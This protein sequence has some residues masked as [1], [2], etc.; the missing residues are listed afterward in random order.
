MDISLVIPAYNE[1]RAIVS[2]I[3]QAIAALEACGPGAHEIIVVDDGSSDNTAELAAQHGAKVVQHLQNLGYGKSLKDGITNAANDAIVIADA[4]G[5]Y[6]IEDLPSL[7]ER[8]ALGFDM[9][10][11]ERTGPNYRES[12]FKS[13]LRKVL[14]LLVEFTTGRRIPDVNSG[15]RVFDRQLAMSYFNHLCDT[16]SFTT[17]LTLSYMMNNK[18]VDYIPISYGP[19]IG[20]TK[21]RL[22]SDSMRT[23]QYISQAILYYDPLKIFAAVSFFCVVL[24]LIGFAMTLVFQLRSTYFLA[25][26]GMLVAILVFCLGLVADLLKQILI[27]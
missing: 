21:V 13:P 4:D 23:L 3:E 24:S 10:V 15:F 2:T 1:E 8:Y 27:K 19:R 11:G 6:P 26:G 16:L 18:F 17:S 14:K 20:K 25:I 12:V 22:L 5:T 7:I 9:V